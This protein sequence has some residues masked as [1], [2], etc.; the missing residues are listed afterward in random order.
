MHGSTIGSLHRTLERIFSNKI[1]LPKLLG[2]WGRRQG[3]APALS[4]GSL[5]AKIEARDFPLQGYFI[6]GRNWIGAWSLEKICV[7]TIIM[8]R[9]IDRHRAHGLRP[10]ILCVRCVAKACTYCSL[11]G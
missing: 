10:Y 4:C 7:V 8:S 1:N 5:L 9:A 6:P 2:I 3:F 11:F